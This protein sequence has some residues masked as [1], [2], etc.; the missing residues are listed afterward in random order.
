M[1]T[2]WYEA[3]VTLQGSHFALDAF[4]QGESCVFRTL[5]DKADY[6]VF[7]LKDKAATI[8]AQ[9]AATS[10]KSRRDAKGGLVRA[11][12]QGYINWKWQDRSG[13]EQARFLSHAVHNAGEGHHA[14]SFL[15]NK[16]A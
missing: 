13:S 10:L 3:A 5:T 1:D 12:D 15:S 16:K 8:D 4:V 11:K 7:D 14:G 9:E 2:D 6:Q